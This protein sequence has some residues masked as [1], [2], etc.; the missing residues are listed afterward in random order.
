MGIL[1][2]LLYNLWAFKKHLKDP[3]SLQTKTFW[4]AYFL[5]SQYMWIWSIIF[6]VAI[7]AIVTI[8]PE[9]ALSIKQLTGLDIANSLPA[10]FTFGL[11]ICSLADTKE[12]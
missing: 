6:I 9:T 10:Y 1:G 4:N 11:G 5:E 8:S 7:S 3:K 2:V 12:R